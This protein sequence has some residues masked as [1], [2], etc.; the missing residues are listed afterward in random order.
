[1]AKLF[2]AEV[3]Q[4]LKSNGE[5]TR[6][7]Q[8]ANRSEPDHIPVVKIFNP[9]GAATW[10]LTEADHDDEDR[11]FG[12]CDLGQGF[13]ELGY[14]SRKELEETRVNPR[15]R[16]H[17]ANTDEVIAGTSKVGLPLE[18]DRHFNT[19]HPLTVW[20][21]AAQLEGRITEDEEVLA[22]AATKLERPKPSSNQSATQEQA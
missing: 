13:P 15:L 4:R 11:L 22:Q 20:L 2:T 9:F 8:D 18:R 19:E 6:K 3:L 17:V 16:V 21:E 1:M 7:R 10:L 12:L 14:V 5:K